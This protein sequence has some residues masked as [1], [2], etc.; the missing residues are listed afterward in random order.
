MPALAAGLIAVVAAAA[1]AV[2][3]WMVKPTAPPASSAIARLT[4]TLPAG[5]ELGDSE[6]PALALSPDG[7]RLV[8]VGRHE[9]KQQLYVRARDTLESTPIAGTEE[10]T[11]PFSL[12][13][14]NGLASSRKVN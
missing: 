4:V 7:A 11:N 14:V 2:A 12:R 6:N 13:T 9:S 3:V 10:A 5:D 8:Y 1:S